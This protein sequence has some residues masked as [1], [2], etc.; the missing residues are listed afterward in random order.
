MSDQE[1]FGQP[2]GV[3]EYCDAGGM[4]WYWQPGVWKRDK[5][6]G[7]ALTDDDLRDQDV[8]PADIFRAPFRVGWLTEVIALDGEW[9]DPQWPVY[10]F[11]KTRPK[12]TP[13]I[14]AS[15]LELG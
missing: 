2:S 6:R 9:C 4:G 5:L 1:T 11:E 13:A 7:A 8:E 3:V 10:R 12:N 15:W 14:E